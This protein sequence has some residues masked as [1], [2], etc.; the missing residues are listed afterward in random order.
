MKNLAKKL[1]VKQQNERVALGKKA[2]KELKELKEIIVSLGCEFLLDDLK[3]SVEVKEI[4]KEVEVVKEVKV[5]VPVEIVKEVKVEVPVE[6]KEL[7]DELKQAKEQIEWFKSSAATWQSKYTKLFNETKDSN[8]NDILS[9]ALK[10]KDEYII[11]LESQ[12]QDKAYIAANDGYVVDGLEVSVNIVKDLNEQINELQEELASKEQ[13]E[14]KYK[15]MNKVLIEEVKAL[16]AKLESKEVIV[17]K[18]VVKEQPVVEKPK[19]KKNKEVIVENKQEVNV[20]ALVECQNYK[21]KREEVS[22]Y[23]GGSFY[24]LASKTCQQITVIPVKSDLE[25]TNDII[26]AYQEQLVKL[27]YKSERTNV[28][29]IVV[30]YKEDVFKGYFARTDAFLGIDKFS[31]DDVFAGYV[32]DRNNCFLFTWDKGSHTKPVVYKLRETVEGKVHN[33]SVYEKNRVCAFVDKMFELYNK[34]VSVIIEE[35]NKKKAENTEKA[36]QIAENNAKRSNDFNAKVEEA[37][38]SG[39]V[40]GSV[41]IGGGKNKRTIKSKNTKSDING[42]S[43]T[44]AAAVSDF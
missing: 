43:D 22:M 28:S 1:L 11:K 40:L 16:Q 23:D 9:Q 37:K 30:N 44:M 7:K 8:N 32:Y 19:T 35:E 31:K 33:V 42:L 27:G 39:K 18:P 5:E 12:L 14:I 24:V 34:E 17:E 36:K 29:P 4:V 3:G 15:E 6:N 38:A 20:R 10:A 2:F 21:R 13:A 41:K 25:V 26:D